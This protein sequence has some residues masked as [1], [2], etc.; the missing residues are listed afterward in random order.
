MESE[1]K[2]LFVAAMASSL[3]LAA[4][5]A[6]AVDITLNF[7]GKVNP[8]TCDIVQDDTTSGSGSSMVKNVPLKSVS[9]RALSQKDD[10][11]GKTL[12]LLKLKDCSGSKVTAKFNTGETVDPQ[13]GALINQTPSGSNVQVQLLDS[14]HQP[15]N[16]NQGPLLD[17]VSIVDQSAVLEFYAQY[18]ASTA[19]TTAGDVSTS[20]SMDLIYE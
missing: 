12:V 10:V 17:T 20:V 3:V 14:K 6:W 5:S 7:T 18:F 8:E 9:T 15:L 1:M 2:N 16:L 13:S 11:A 4:S 19:G